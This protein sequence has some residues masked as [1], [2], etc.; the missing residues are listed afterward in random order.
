MPKVSV[1]VP[2]YNHERFLEKRIQSVLDQTY[3]DFELIILDDASPDNSKQVIENF[4]GDQRIR[5]I[6]NQTNSGSTFKQWNKGICEAKGEYI[7]LAESDDYADECLLAELVAKLEQYPNV[8]I[9]QCQSWQIDEHDNILCSMAD[10][11]ADLNETRWQQDFVNNGKD[12]CN[13]YLIVRCTIPNASAVLIRKSIYD[14]VGGADEKLRLCGDWMLW[15]KMLLISDIAFVGKP[16]N[17]FRTHSNTVRSNSERNALN[18]EES[19]Q[20]RTY[21]LSNTKLNFTQA[22]I[23]KI[24][25]GMVGHWVNIAFADLARISLERNHRIYKLLSTIDPK[26][27]QRL[28]LKIVIRLFMLKKV[29]EWFRYVQLKTV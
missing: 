17:Y 21:M 2:N 1:I 25:D 26:L 23:N 18:I 14:Q 10:S 27:K 24:C 9:A 16:L 12:E 29:K 20:V 5:T 11:T 15:A 22:R 6:Y 8:G 13:K 4:L 28:I 3:Q 19:C 7:W